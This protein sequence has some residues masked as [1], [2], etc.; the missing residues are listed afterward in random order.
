MRVQE[1]RVGATERHWLHTRLAD[2]TKDERY[3]FTRLRSKM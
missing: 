2:E 3:S 1:R